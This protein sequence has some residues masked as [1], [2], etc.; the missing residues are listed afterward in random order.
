MKLILNLQTK[1]KQL[2]K[3]WL[4][5]FLNQIVKMKNKTIKIQ[6]IIMNNNKVFSNI[7]ILTIRKTVVQDLAN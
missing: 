3:N 6:E 5:I 2:T 1:S 7:K 4:N